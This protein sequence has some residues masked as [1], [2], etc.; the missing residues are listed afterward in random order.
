MFILITLI[1]Y[2]GV[3]GECINVK[4]FVIVLKH[5][6]SF[7]KSLIVIGNFGN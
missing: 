4:V 5:V 1:R 3:G 6:G 7:E 2:S